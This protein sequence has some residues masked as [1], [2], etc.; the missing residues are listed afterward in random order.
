MAH[1][2]TKSMHVTMELRAEIEWEE[3]SGL[4][5]DGGSFH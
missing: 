2:M 4:V 3:E 5:E 1:G